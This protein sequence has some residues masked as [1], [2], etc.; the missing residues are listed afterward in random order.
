MDLTYEM[1][2][3][4]FDVFGYDA[5]IEER[6]DLIPPKKDRRSQLLKMDRFSRNSVVGSDGR[7]VSNA[8]LFRSATREGRTRMYRRSSTTALKGSLVAMNKDEILASVAGIRHIS[9]VTEDSMETEMEG[10]GHSKK[11]D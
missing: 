3:H 5:A 1:Y 2:H 10:S 4:D 8:D 7:R 9:I 11:D 6:P